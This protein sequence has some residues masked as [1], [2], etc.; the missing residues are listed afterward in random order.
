MSLALKDILD[1]VKTLVDDVTNIENVYTR[2]VVYSN[3]ERFVELFRTKAKDRFF[4][5]EIYRTTRQSQLLSFKNVYR[6]VHTITVRGYISI[7]EQGQTM[8]YDVLSGFLQNIQD[9]FN[10]NL[11]L[12]N[13][14]ENSEPATLEEITMD[15][16][17]GRVLWAGNVTWV[18]YEREIVG[19]IS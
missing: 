11:T 15:V 5:F 18:L 1:E 7:Y 3:S 16:L 4:G 10:V 19:N 12:N 6:H 17:T 14:M 9:K 8:S 2:R 13:T